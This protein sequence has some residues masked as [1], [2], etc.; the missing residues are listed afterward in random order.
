[1]KR[2]ADRKLAEDCKFDSSP[3]SDSDKPQNHHELQT[4]YRPVSEIPTVE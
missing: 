1:M 4:L 2:P 3:S